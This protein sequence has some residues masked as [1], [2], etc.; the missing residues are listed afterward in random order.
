VEQR[1][2]NANAVVSIPRDEDRAVPV[3]ATLEREIATAMPRFHAFLLPALLGLSVTASACAELSDDAT[4]D[5]NV[6]EATSALSVA[7]WGGNMSMPDSW[8]GTQ[9]ASLNGVTYAVSVGTCGNWDCWP[10]QDENSLNWA[11]L[12]PYGWGSKGSIPNQST[13]TK[14]NL[15]AFNGYLYMVHTG[16]DN[17][18]QTWISRMDPATQQWSANYQIPYTSFDGPPAIVAYNNLLYFIGT[19]TYPYAMW[20]ATMTANESFSGQIAIPG[21]DAASHASAA[22][23]NGKLYF[24]HRWGQ[25]ADIVYGSFN[26]SVWATAKHIPGGDAGGTLR[27]L[28][29]AIAVENGLLHLVHLRTEGAPYVWWTTFNGCDWAGAEVT[30]NTTQSAKGPSL[31]QSGNGLQ[32]VTA[33]GSSGAFG[34]EEYTMTSRAYTRPFSRFPPINVPCD[35]IIVEQ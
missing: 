35:I 8:R 31:T 25:T 4:V 17:G 16:S 34:I 6:A 5:D 19:G 33:A 27:G 28:E 21:H 20:Y 3:L 15:A 23:L 9:V 26:G 1:L 24:A 11:V 30:L 2:K 13:N 18:S 10:Y 29:P 7:N 12:G 32:V 14:V 22:V